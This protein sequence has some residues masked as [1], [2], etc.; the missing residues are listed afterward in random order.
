[1]AKKKQTELEDFLNKHETTTTD[2]EEV[3]TLNF[4]RDTVYEVT[5]HAHHSFDGKFGPSVVVTYENESGKHKAF[6][7]GFE[8][9]HFTN[10]IADKQ[11][12]I[13]VKLARV[14]RESEQNEGRVYNKL[15]ITE[16]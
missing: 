13:D 3:D 4:E 9:G 12:P 11:L 15:V 1:M 16:L 2:F 10:F 5:V 14:Q 6:I 8:A 7:N